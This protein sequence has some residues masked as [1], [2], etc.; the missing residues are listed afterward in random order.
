M[1]GTFTG[2]SYYMAPERIRGLPYTITSDV[3]SLGLTVLELASNRFPF[4]PEGEPALGP[5][6]LLSYIITMRVPELKDDTNMGVKWT[7]AFKD[8]LENC[9]EK[10][11]TKRYGPVKMLNHPFMKKS[12]SRVP[13][14]NMAKFVA[15]VWGWDYEEEAGEVL[16]KTKTKTEAPVM[17]NVDVPGLG[18]VASIR[19]APSP[20]AA[21]GGDFVRVVPPKLPSLA[22][23]PAPSN[24]SISTSASALDAEGRTA[25]ERALAKQREA[26]VGLIGSP[27]EEF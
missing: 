24:A 7:K 16:Q 18:R 4:P 17:E 15:D 13:Q 5:I 9:L 23:I 12:I 14:P 8:Y 3:W 20:L 11:G 27:T 1:A 22:S 2:T 25:S 6:D 26:D 10:D 21:S 19:K